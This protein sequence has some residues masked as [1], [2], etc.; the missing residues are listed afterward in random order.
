M[1]LSAGQQSRRRHREQ[2]CGR[3]GKE[4]VDGWRKRVEALPHRKQPASRRQLEDSELRASTGDNLGSGMEREL[5]GRFRVGGHM[6]THG[7]V[8]MLYGRGHHDIMESLSSS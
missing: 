7:R 5:G 4:R 1:G 3:G 2:T 6:C 8:M